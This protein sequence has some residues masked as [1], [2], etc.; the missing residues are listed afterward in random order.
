[1]AELIVAN[2][3]VNRRRS[4]KRK[5]NDTGHENAEG[6]ASVGVRVELTVRLGREVEDWAC[7]QELKLKCYCTVLCNLPIFFLNLKSRPR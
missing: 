3:Q 1:M 4:A 6:M 5:G 2:A 7:W